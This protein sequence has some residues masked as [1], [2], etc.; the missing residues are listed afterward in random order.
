[1]SRWSSYP[2]LR[3]ERAGTIFRRLRPVLLQKLDRAANKDEALVA[4]DGFLSGLPAGVQLFALFEAN[5]QMMDLII[6][7]ASTAPD[8][9]RYLSRNAGVFDAVIGGSF[10]DAWP[11]ADRLT[12]DLAA[13]MDAIPDYEKKLD[14][15]RRWMKEWHFR[16]GVHHLRGLI[17][18]F[19]AGKL[20]ADLARA[21]L[22]AIWP[23]V[24]AEFARRHGPAPGRGAMV[25]GMGSLGAGRLNAG[26]DLDL[27]VIYDAAGD[28]A[29]DGPKPLAARPYF[30][31][32]T[33]AL[34]TALTAAM[35]EGRL[36]EVDMRLR[37]SGRQGPV[38]TSVT[39][40]LDYQMTEAWTWEHL[41]LTRAR[42]LA[43][44]P[45]LMAKVEGL[46][47]QVLAAKGG[48]DKVTADVAEMR[49]RLQ[50]AKPAGPGWEAKNGPGRLMDIELLAQTCALR[51]G[52]GA[53]APE[54]QLAAGRKAGLLTAAEE[55]ALLAAYRLLWRLHAAG[56]LI[57]NRTPDPAQ[58]GLGA[59]AFVLRE[60]GAS[61]SDALT[62]QLAQSVTQAAGII[63]THLP[64]GGDDGRTG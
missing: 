28:E 5:P 21:V 14:G 61:S 57:A 63:G 1:M 13:A 41:A 10:W 29:S 33:Q 18:G 53:R 58:L 22:G 15:A 44:P 4:I 19:E 43:G 35:P 3:S 52:D 50:A 55:T 9:A 30:A 38:A 46:R 36:Y 48:G 2:A 59:A 37:P 54:A 32:L 40:F 17:D 6:D 24:G 7:I 64:A 16:V 51:A 26:S 25:L 56:R 62:A 39:S 34:V 20:Y 12:A 42:P 60:T 31:R 47:R 11:G 27:I 49:A 23:A 8:L 45:D